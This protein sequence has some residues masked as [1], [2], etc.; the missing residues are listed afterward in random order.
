MRVPTRKMPESSTVSTKE[1]RTERGVIFGTSFINEIIDEICRRHFVACE[2]L[3][4]YPPRR[5]ISSTIR[6]CK[7]SKECFVLINP[8]LELQRLW[9]SDWYGSKNRETDLFLTTVD[10]FFRGQPASYSNHGLIDQGGGLFFYRNIVAIKRVDFAKVDGDILCALNSVYE[11]RMD[12]R[13]LLIGV[14][15]IDSI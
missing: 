8:R 14:S 1:I 7:L 9:A 3:P 15:C 10:V 2:S 13:A 12:V 5:L 4:L 11:G 6:G